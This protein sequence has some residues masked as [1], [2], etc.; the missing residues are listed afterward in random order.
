MHGLPEQPAVNRHMEPDWWSWGASVPL[1]NSSNP[2]REPIRTEVARALCSSAV[3][4][5]GWDAE[6]CT[7]LRD[8]CGLD[9]SYTLAGGAF[10][11][12]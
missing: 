4:C 2:F 6:V 10:W 8:L 3:E 5:K 12:D 7:T 11:H 1:V 9:T